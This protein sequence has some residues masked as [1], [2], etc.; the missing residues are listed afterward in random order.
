[1]DWLNREHGSGTIIKW[2]QEVLSVFGKA[3]ASEKAFVITVLLAGLPLMQDPGVREFSPATQSAGFSWVPG[4]AQV[5]C[6]WQLGEPSCLLPVSLLFR[7]KHASGPLA[8]VVLVLSVASV[9]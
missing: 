4:E 5:F 9:F 8:C 3:Y 2:L 7:S 6:G 1:M